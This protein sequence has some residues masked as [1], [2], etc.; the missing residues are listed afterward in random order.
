[1][2]KRFRMVAGPN[3]SGKSTLTA[4]LVGDYSVNFYT[5][6]NAD[7]VFAEVSR[8]RMFLPPFPI[9]G[10]SL[11]EYAAH[12]DYA[13]AEKLRFAT[14]EIAVDADCVRF[15]TDASVNSYTVALLVNFLQDECI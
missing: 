9:D 1:M 7:D 3:G 15:G 11:S 8:T 13:E 12:T 14:G 6:L 4:R 2:T 5:R 10:V